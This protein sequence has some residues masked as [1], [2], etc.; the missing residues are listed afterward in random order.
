[1]YYRNEARELIFLMMIGDTEKISLLEEIYIIY[2]KDIYLTA[3]DM[4]KKPEVAED[5]CHTA[6]IKA[7]EHLEKIS[8]VKSKKTR[9]YLV[10]IVM[11][12]CRDYFKEDKVKGV[13]MLHSVPIDDMRTLKDT[14]YLVEEGFLKKELMMEISEL[15]EQIHPSYSEVIRMRYYDERS[16]KEI[17]GMLGTTENNVSVRINRGIKAMRKLYFERRESN[18]GIITKTERA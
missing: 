15:I 7:S 12:L 3:Y 18:D 5:I 1:M 2:K 17:A 9:S 14:K 11:N 13:H 16:I 6:I 4:V 10:S 8:D